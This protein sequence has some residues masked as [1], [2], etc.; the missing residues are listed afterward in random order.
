MLRA[1]IS[2][3]GTVEDRIQIVESIPELD[4]AATE[5]LRQWRFEPARNSDGQVVRVLV[6]VP[7]R[8]RLR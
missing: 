2:T 3:V 7:L 8:F 4:S 6:E 5:A 1:I